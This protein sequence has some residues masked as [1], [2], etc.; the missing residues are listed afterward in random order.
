M[1]TYSQSLMTKKFKNPW[2]DVL[3]GAPLPWSYSQVLPL[4]FRSSS[5]SA[6]RRVP[7]CLCHA[8]WVE[9]TILLSRDF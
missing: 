6:Q 1:I 2:P 8:V 3:R 5:L 9:V 4:T 7:L